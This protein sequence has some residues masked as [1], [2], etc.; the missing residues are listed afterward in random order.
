MPKEVFP[1]ISSI[2]VEKRFTKN[3]KIFGAVLAHYFFFCM[4]KLLQEMSKSPLPV[5][6]GFRRFKYC[7]LPSA[8]YLVLFGILYRRSLLK[9]S[10]LKSVTAVSLLSVYAH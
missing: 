9:V 7:M 4:R 10:T 1:V 5:E 8:C 2:I 6:K 3:I